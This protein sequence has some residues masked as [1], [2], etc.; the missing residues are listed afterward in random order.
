MS[1]VKIIPISLLL[2]TTNATSSTLKENLIAEY[3]SFYCPHCYKFEPV[4]HKI[5]NIYSDKARI[6]KRHASFMGGEFGPKLSQLYAA[7]TILGLQDQIT[8]K[9]FSLIHDKDDKYFSDVE[10]L[11]EKINFD[12]KIS[13]QLLKENYKLSSK[14]LS[15]FYQKAFKESGLTAVPNVTI[16]SVKL[17]TKGVDNLK[18]YFEVVNAML[19]KK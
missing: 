4:V 7:S 2:L 6:V 17:D 13:N 11:L 15:D 10:T 1:L 19:D 16:N 8:P 18:Q 9:I 3:F 5:E 14:L 12:K